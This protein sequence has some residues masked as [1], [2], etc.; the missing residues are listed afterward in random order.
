MQPSYP[1]MLQMALVAGVGEEFTAVEAGVVGE[2]TNHG[3]VGESKLRCINMCIHG[4][5]NPV[6]RFVSHAV[7]AASAFS[8]LASSQVRSL[9]DLVDSVL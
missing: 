2:G 6:V 9:V 5:M 4:L 1:H 3:V 7:R 8:A